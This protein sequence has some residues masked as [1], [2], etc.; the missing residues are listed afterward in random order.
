MHL[1]LEF[2]A[3]A[4]LLLLAIF[5]I[6]LV[7]AYYGGRPITLMDII[8]IGEKPKR[9]FEINK[10]NEKSAK[11]PTE[12]SLKYIFNKV[13]ELENNIFISRSCV[14]D[15]KRRFVR[16]PDSKV[17]TEIESFLSGKIK[18]HD[19]NFT[20][21]NPATHIIVT[22][23]PRYNQYAALIQKYFDLPFQYVISCHR[24]GVDECIIEIVTKYGECL[25]SS[26]DIRAE[27]SDV[28]VDYGILF[29]GMLE[30]GKKAIWLSGIHAM[31]LT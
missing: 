4:V 10:S 17:V 18:Y 1:L 19:N 29:C 9:E 27:L 13:L 22:G 24:H 23:S 25:T 16:D 12:T 26:K 31:P 7:F 28:D 21:A 5:I 15:Q 2:G 30:N 8:K 6:L 14:I 20:I 3:Y 11:T